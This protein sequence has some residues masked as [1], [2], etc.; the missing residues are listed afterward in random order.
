MS[1]LSNRS[2]VNFI[3]A[4]AGG[5]SNAISLVACIAANL[6]AFIAI[7]S[8]VNATLMWFGHRVGVENLTYEVT[9]SLTNLICFSRVNK[10]KLVYQYWQKDRNNCQN[11][12]NVGFSRF[13]AGIITK[14][15]QLYVLYE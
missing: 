4:A 15:S 12:S 5:A 8:F 2:H 9:Q 11:N 14:M 3:E 10:L 1:L 6:I 7:L 13:G